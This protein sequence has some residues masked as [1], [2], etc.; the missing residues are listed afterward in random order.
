MPCLAFFF[1]KV[2]FFFLCSFACFLRSHAKFKHLWAKTDIGLPLLLI[3]CCAVC[4]AVSYL[5][6]WLP[7]HRETVLICSLIQRRKLSTETYWRRE[8]AQ[9]TNLGLQYATPELYSLHYACFSTSTLCFFPY[10]EISIHVVRVPSF[11]TVHRYCSHSKSKESLFVVPTVFFLRS[12]SF[13][14][15]CTL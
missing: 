7:T 1:I 9:H 13:H 6:I 11:P 15:L 2:G 5:C 4:E 14:H 8:K 3:Y 12:K 10:N